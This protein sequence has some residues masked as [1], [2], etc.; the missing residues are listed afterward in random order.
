MPRLIGGK[1]FNLAADGQGGA[2]AVHGLQD[3]R[4]VGAAGRHPGQGVREVH[5]LPGRQ[6]CPGCCTRGSCARRRSTRRSSRSTAFQSG[7]PPDV[8]Q[9]VQKSNY[10]AVVATTRMGRDQGAAL[11]EGDVEHGAA[12]PS[13]ATFNDDLRRRQAVDDQVIQDSAFD[14]R[15]ERRR[16]CS[17]RRAAKTMSATYK[18]PIQMHGSMGASASTAWCRR[19]NSATVWS[20]TQAIYP[21]RAMLATALEHPAAEHPRASTSRAPGCYGHE[22]APTTSRSTPR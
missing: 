8:V 1:Q 15:P 12:L 4:H 13:W 19:A 2:E 11:A 14:D 6:A 9:V 21:L 16:A 20:S 22:R 7:K 5:V 17:P 18:Y 3:R 10:V